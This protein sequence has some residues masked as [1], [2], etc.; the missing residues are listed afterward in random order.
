MVHNGC[1]PRYQYSMYAVIR[2]ISNNDHR[3]S[4][5]VTT[6]RHDFWYD[7]VDDDTAADMYR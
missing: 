3:S 2:I 6:A 4:P 5:K 1:I 7:I